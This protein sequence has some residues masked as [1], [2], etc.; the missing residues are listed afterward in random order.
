MPRTCLACASPE[1]SQIDTGIV[2]G[3][4]LREISEKFRIAIS[5]LHRHKAHAAGSI[6]KAA[7]RR[8]ES[9]GDNLLGEMRRVQRKAWELLG[10]AEAK[11][12]HR[13]LIVALRKVRECIDALGSMLKRAT[14]ASGGTTWTI[15]HR[16]LGQAPIHE[17]EEL[18]ASYA[19]LLP[20]KPRGKLYIVRE[21]V[22][23][24]KDAADA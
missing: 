17:W 1:R 6:V 9:L 18:P 5:S 24:S 11:G 23:Q 2:S 19:A 22:R 20:G 14:E 15:R 12:D 10:K 4:P 8:E 16:Y 7:E 13:G 21:H 3:R